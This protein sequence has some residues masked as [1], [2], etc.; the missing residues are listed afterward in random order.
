VTIEELG[1]LVA[2][3]E[4]EHLEFK[5]STGSLSD[6]IKTVCAMLNAAVPG[7]V[8]FG[9]SDRG[10]L[11]GQDVSTRTLED[12]ANEL[13]KMEP[14]CAHAVEQR[15][16]ELTGARS[17]I[18]LLVRGDCEVYTFDGGPYQRVGP[19]TGVMPRWTYGQRLM[20]RLHGTRRWEL[21][22]ALDRV[23]IADLDEE[24]FLVT[25]DSA[26]R[27]GRMERPRNLD[28]EALLRGL[29]LIL[30]DRLVN[31]AV[32]LYGKSRWME[33]YYPQMAIRLGRFGGINRLADFIDNRQY[34]GHAFS[35]L[36]QAE[37]F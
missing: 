26:M 11:V 13:R 14:P 28:T 21:E 29:G 19:T 18:V 2:Q 24:E 1:M 3:G 15:V 22:P 10:D 4:S 12:V 32:I 36:R 8:L 5:R 37:V 20:E 17:A 7:V 25:V 6:G 33:G 27:L 35:L 23:T 31:A 16:I 34:W 9:V 30:A